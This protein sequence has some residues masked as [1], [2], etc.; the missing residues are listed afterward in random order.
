MVQTPVSL[1]AAGDRA[2]ADARGAAA[3]AGRLRDAG[4]HLERVSTGRPGK[5]TGI[6]A[7]I[8]HEIRYDHPPG[9]CCAPRIAGVHATRGGFRTERHESALLTPIAS[10]PGFRRAGRACHFQPLRGTPDPRGAG[11]RRRRDGGRLSIDDLVLVAQNVRGGADVASVVGFHAVGRVERRGRGVGSLSSFRAGVDH[12]F[13]AAVVASGVRRAGIDH[14][15]TTPA[16][17]KALTCA[18]NWVNSRVKR[19]ISAP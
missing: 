12:L 15:L 8:V 1:A 10:S 6:R 2:A 7:P 18:R 19:F 13:V 11:R 9:R 17:A 14:A 4:N 3:G 5:S 16:A